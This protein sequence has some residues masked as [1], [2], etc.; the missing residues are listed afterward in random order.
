MKVHSFN[1]D[2]VL[3]IEP[4]RVHDLRG[5]FCETY[6]ATE[7]D[8]HGVDAAFVQDNL[9]LSTA[10][11]TVRG[12]HFQSPPYAQ[13][14]LVRVVRGAIFDV[15]V[16]IRGG[17][18]TFGKYVGVEL[19]AENG[20]Q[21]Y[22]P[23]GFA[24]GFATLRPLTEIAYKVTAHYSPDHDMGIFWDDPSLRIRWPVSPDEAVLSP[25]DEGL[26][27]LRE[28]QTPFGD[29]APEEGVAA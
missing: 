12:L 8:R 3:L 9:S 13:A 10:C 16:D 2:G 1:I 6:N 24:H 20:L 17:S 21:L 28:I 25:K 22:I 29:K 7:L 11:G 14:K 26:P 18:P 5:F 15:A 19:S 27:L 23:T 4:R